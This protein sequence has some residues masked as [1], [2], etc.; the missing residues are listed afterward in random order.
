MVRKKIILN[1]EKKATY[2]LNS[3]DDQTF[4]YCKTHLL[5]YNEIWSIND[6]KICIQNKLGHKCQF[7]KKLEIVA[8]K[9]VLMFLKIRKKKYFCTTHYKSDL[10]KRLKEY[11]PQ[12]IKNMIVKKYPTSKLQLNLI[13]KLDELSEHFAKLKI[14][15]VIIE[16]QPSQKNPKMKSIAIHYLIIL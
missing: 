3:G 11:S 14:Q 5:Q 6:T 13:K 8:T 10:N 1:V 9:K 2:C 15:E 4:G 16:N 7:L 12:P